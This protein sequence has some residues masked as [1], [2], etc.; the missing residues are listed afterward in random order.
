MIV[1]QRV[2]EVVTWS[3][4]L[5]RADGG[6]LEYTEDDAFTC[7]VWAGDDAESAL[8]PSVTWE[9]APNVVA[10]EIDA[11]TLSRGEY[12]CRITDSGDADVAWWTLRVLPAPGTADAPATYC[13]FD[14]LLLYA[15]WLAE[16]ASADS[17]QGGFVEQRGRARQWIDAAIQRRWR[18]PA[19]GPIS[20]SATTVWLGTPSDPTGPSTWLQ[21][22]LDDDG[23]VVSAAIREAAAK[24]AVS[25]VCG[26][27]LGDARAGTSYG[28]LAVRYHAEAEAALAST[29]VQID[30]DDDGDPDLVI[31]M[32]SVVVLRG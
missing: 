28:S 24:F 5:H 31:D 19:Y 18:P 16:L 17:D 21:D 26:A 6:A 11:A 32:S 2:G 15:P 3:I 27:Q 22:L 7:Q 20:L 23:L 14:D 29:S 8:T 25:L 4:T 12:Q 13:S 30:V 10:V 9:T 1:E